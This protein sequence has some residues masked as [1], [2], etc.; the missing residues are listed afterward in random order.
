LCIRRK[1]LEAIED[2]R[3]SDLPGPTYAFGFVR[4]YAE[5]LGLN[6]P[7][8]AHRFREETGGETPLQALKFPL[9]LSENGV[10]KGAMIL[11]GAL[12]L[13]IAYSVW[14]VDSLSGS[15][16]VKLVNP[17]PER[18]A[19]PRPGDTSNPPGAEGAR[20]GSGI[21]GHGRSG[22]PG[23]AD[24]TSIGER[25]AAPPPA[26]AT[27]PEATTA[28][29]L[30]GAAVE[31]HRG[32]VGRTAAVD[33][34]ADGTPPAISA[35]TPRESEVEPA[36]SPPPAAAAGPFDPARIGP[37]GSGTVARVIVRAHAECWIEIKDDVTGKLIFARLLRPGES[38]AVPDR[39]GLKLL[40]GN[41]GGIDVLV[42]S[43]PMPALGRDGAVVRNISLEPDRLRGTTPTPRR[44]G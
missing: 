8:L 27:T 6:G 38:Y 43:V 14:Y 21:A 2:G 10:P 24:D 5:Y 37:D 17:V 41:A 13:G 23:S 4:A 26:L 32:L 19:G 9:P 15:H 40:A 33:A 34:V 7:A 35:R 42:D 39:P 29:P 30:A 11:L 18:F 12:I 31:A 44:D 36:A 3:F 16:L 22:G 28:R 1:Y 25:A 20:D